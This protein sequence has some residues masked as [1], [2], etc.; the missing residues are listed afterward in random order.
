MSNSGF[1]QIW[2]QRMLKEEL[3]KHNITEKMCLLSSNQDISLWNN[4]WVKGQKIT[5]ILNKTP[6]YLQKEFD[7][8]DNIIPNE[9]IYL[10]SYM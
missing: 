2:L 7:N 10:F 6:I 5:K 9:E 3:L 1:A 8:L 4:S